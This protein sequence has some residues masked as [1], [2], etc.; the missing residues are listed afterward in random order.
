MDRRV[1]IAIGIGAILLMGVLWL[2]FT[3]KDEQVQRP[4]PLPNEQDTPEPTIQEL[5][6]QEAE[7]VGFTF[8]QNFLKSGPPEPDPKAQQEAYDALSQIAKQRVAQDTLTRDLA[9]FVGVQ[10]IPDQ[11]VSVED[12]QREGDTATLIVGLNFS[13]GQSLR[14]VELIVE[15]GEWKVNNI[16]PLEQYPASE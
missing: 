3:P 5:S 9:L 14:A 4:I 6:D 7:Q 11:G 10:D 8:M 12:L 16:E 13:G 1:V 2:V 15:E